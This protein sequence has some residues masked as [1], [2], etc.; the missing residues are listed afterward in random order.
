MLCTKWTPKGDLDAELTNFK[1]MHLG[2]FADSEVDA[3]MLTN[4][5]FQ[6][7]SSTR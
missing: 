3:S 7:I 4:Y 5:S 2:W 6:Q 1:D